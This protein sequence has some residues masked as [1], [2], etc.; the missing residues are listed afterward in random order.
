MQSVVNFVWN[1]LLG[2]VHLFY[3]TLATFFCIALWHTQYLYTRARLPVSKRTVAS[4]GWDQLI[5]RTQVDI[6][7]LNRVQTTALY[8]AYREIL[9][10]SLG[11]GDQEKFNWITADPEAKP[12]RKKLLGRI[13]ETPPPYA[14]LLQNFG[15]LVDNFRVRLY[16]RDQ[17]TCD[18]GRQTGKTNSWKE[19]VRSEIAESI[20]SDIPDFFLTESQRVYA[21]KSA[22]AGVRMR[23]ISQRVTTTKQGADVPEK[24]TTL[25]DA[26]KSQLEKSDMYIWLFT[27]S[28]ESHLR[29]CYFYDWAV[30]ETAIL[31][32]T[33]L[34]SLAADEDP[35]G[36]VSLRLP[37]VF[38]L[39]GDVV[40]SLRY[41]QSTP[42]R[43]LPSQ[44][45]LWKPF[46][47]DTKVVPIEA[48]VASFTEPKI[49]LMEDC[50]KKLVVAFGK[51]VLESLRDQFKSDVLYHKLIQYT[52][53]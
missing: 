25:W 5:K 15:K 31:A 36:L 24:L 49:K 17:A 39:I 32:V 42:P 51:P 1:R 11:R 9:S 33:Q 47:S 22:C 26:F 29:T 52:V 44:A 41:L 34:T 6:G 46:F 30:V 45:Q 16:P 4:S 8:D 18:V 27:T 40:D 37:L 2:F 53:V 43:H 14:H 50:Q 23:G 21:D 13:E 3:F 20:S 10:I 7:K 19:Q 35:Y 48:V 38:N 12:L 28:L